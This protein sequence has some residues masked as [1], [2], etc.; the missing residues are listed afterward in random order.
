LIAFF[1]DPPEPERNRIRVRTNNRIADAALLIAAVALNHL[2]G[3]G[4]NAG[5]M[6]AGTSPEGQPF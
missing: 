5:L 4:D 6:G 1:H 2:T 3:A